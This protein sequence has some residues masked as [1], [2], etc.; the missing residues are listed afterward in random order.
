MKAE[1]LDDIIAAAGPMVVEAL[2]EIS[3]GILEAAAGK[4]EEASMKDSDKDTQGKITLSIPLRLSIRL[5]KSPPVA[6]IA[7]AT[8][9]K[10]ESEIGAPEPKTGAERTREYR[11]RQAGTAPQ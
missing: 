8:S 7:A 6:S 3:E 1:E 11:L 10:W 2:G 9:R 5:D 4:L